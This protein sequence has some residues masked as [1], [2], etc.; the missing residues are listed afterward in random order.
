MSIMTMTKSATVRARIEPDLKEEGDAILQRLGM[1]TSDLITMTY[2]Q[3]VM[4]KGIPFP[5][6]IPN[7]ETI[8][9][10]NEPVEGLDRYTSSEEMMN[11]ILGE[12]D[13]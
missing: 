11:D 3:L 6:R 13:N 10:I 4:R 1:S 12:S 9:A 7:A 5:V 8:A 2:K